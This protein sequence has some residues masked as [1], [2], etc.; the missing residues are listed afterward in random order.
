MGHMKESGTTVTSAPDAA[1]AIAADYDAHGMEL[2]GVALHALGDRGLAE[3]VVQETFVRA[4]RAHDRFDAERASRR[5]WLFA[6]LRNL[7]IDAARSRSRR[8]HLAGADGGPERAAPEADAP[9]RVVQR[10]S[11]AHAITAL[12]TDHRRAIVEVFVRDRPYAD[13]AEDL[14]VPVGTVRSRVHYALVDLRS[15]LTDAFDLGVADDR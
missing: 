4:W 7:V 1:A 5:T 10:L 11:I 9:D 3:E 6:I 8:P 14:G 13:V 15:R 12:S 2:F